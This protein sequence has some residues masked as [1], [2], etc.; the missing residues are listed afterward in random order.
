MDDLHD[1]IAQLE[2]RIE[3][4]RATRERCRKISLVGRIALYISGLWLILTLTSLLPFSPTP[5]FAA[6]A[7]VLGG[8][9]LLGSNKTTWE[10]TEEELRKAEAMRDQFIGSITMKVVGDER[11]TLH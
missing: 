8:F 7:A 5:F 4:L 10:Q 2:T 6:L 1:D 11:P 3:E 9:V